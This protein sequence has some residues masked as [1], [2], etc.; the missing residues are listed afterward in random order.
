MLR[1]CTA[2]ALALTISGCSSS[3]IAPG[4]A[5]R[6]CAP[7]PRIAGTWKSGRASQLGRARVTFRFHCDCS[8]ESDARVVFH[9]IRE[10]GSWWVDG[11]RLSFTRGNGTTTSWAFRFEAGRLVLAEGENE[12]HSYERSSPEQCSR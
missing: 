2:A 10:R 8:Y 1:F 11:G 5:S 9:R 6:A 3:S 12:E 7:D 4:S